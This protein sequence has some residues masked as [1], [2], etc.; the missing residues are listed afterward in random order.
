MIWIGIDAALHR[1]LARGVT[2][3]AD[4]RC[5]I[6]LNQGAIECAPEVLPWIQE[7]PEKK[8]TQLEPI[9]WFTEWH[10]MDN[11]LCTHPPSMAKGTA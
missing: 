11:C 5:L 3:G 8:V 7:W 4:F 9:C 1:N 6:P 10:Y 2:F